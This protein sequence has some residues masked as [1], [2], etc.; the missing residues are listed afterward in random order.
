MYIVLCVFLRCAGD[1]L[2]EVDSVP[3]LPGNFLDSQTVSSSVTTGASSGTTSASSS[4]TTVSSS[5]TTAASS[6]TII[7]SCCFLWYNCCFLW[8]NR[9]FVCITLVDFYF[10]LEIKEKYQRILLPAS[11]P[12]IPEGILLLV[13][14]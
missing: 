12:S 9:F 6:G 11:R 10:R 14:V 1:G 3:L 5:V 2:E 13:Q 7:S 8:Y 4:V